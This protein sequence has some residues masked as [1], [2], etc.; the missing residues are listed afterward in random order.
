MAENKR[1]PVKWIRDKAKAAYEKDSCC[2]ICETKEHLELHHL[3]SVTLLLERWCA[4]KGYSIDTD[5]QV[6]AIRDEFI[7]AHRVEL[8]DEVYTLCNEHHVKLHG[9]YGKIPAI[10]SSKRQANWIQI[11]RDK[12]VGKIPTNVS[13]SPFS[14]FLKGDP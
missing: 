2:Y 7:E 4:S 9:I 11:Q 13:P 6:V 1:I 8:Y 14:K 12:L 5:E 10:G 3:N